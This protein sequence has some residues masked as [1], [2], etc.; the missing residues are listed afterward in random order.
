[1]IPS[2]VK[3]DKL[4][5]I[6][7]TD[8]SGDFTFSRGSD[9]QATRVN[10]SG[11][12]EKAKV[13]LLKYSQDFSKSDWIKN[14]GVTTTHSQTDPNGATTATRL[15]FA[16]GG[17]YYFY[18]PLFGVGAGVYTCSVWV[19]GVSGSGQI[20]FSTGT[21]VPRTGAKINYTTQWQRFEW[22]ANETTSNSGIQFD[23]YSDGL[24][25]VGADFYI[26]FAQVNHGL[27]AQDYVETTTTAVVEGLT[28]DLPRLDYSGGAS[29]PSLLLEPS[30]TNF[31][32]HSE[33]FSDWA[34]D[35]DGAGQS[36]T[37]NY[38]ISPEGVQNAY[39][40]QLDTTGGTTR[41]TNAELVALTTI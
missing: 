40:L 9:I 20:C 16:S 1:M 32:P 13:N 30:R 38:S 15:T 4:Y 36:V 3:E 14:A 27:I 11:L 19:K 7:P 2:G 12:I 21:N 41:L 34:L 26:A 24:S 17:N 25:Q 23:N 10:S 29:C 33:Y 18:Q 5:S 22:Y 37:A 28:A 31:I 8:G 39:R 35:G 6:K